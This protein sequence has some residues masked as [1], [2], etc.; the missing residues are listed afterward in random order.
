LDDCLFTGNTVLYDLREWLQANPKLDVERL[1]LL[2]HTVHS[3][4]K[5]YV[6]TGI[7]SDDRLEPFKNK[8]LIQPEKTI[9]NSRSRDDTTFND[10]PYDCFWP[11]QPTNPSNG[12]QHHIAQLEANSRYYRP[13][14]RTPHSSLFSTPE[15]RRI[16]EGHFLEK[17]VFIMTQ[18]KTVQPS[19]RPLGYENLSSLGFGAMYVTYRNISNN[20]P[21]VLWW[22]DPNAAIG[23][24]FRSWYPLIPRQ[25]NETQGNLP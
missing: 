25:I 23:H 17:G 13:S 8:T 2:F 4:G 18:P 12:L 1:H 20:C 5:Y 10:R 9:Q 19:M 14:I 3:G 16:T 21:L 6:E 11:E 24:P 7:R 15:S 22:G